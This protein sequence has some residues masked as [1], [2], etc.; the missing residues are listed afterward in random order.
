[1]FA[2]RKSVNVVGETR[3][4]REGFFFLKKRR[5]DR[6]VQKKVFVS[7]ILVVNLCCNYLLFNH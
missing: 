3:R 7:R 6:A 1:M 4:L 2:D 5:V